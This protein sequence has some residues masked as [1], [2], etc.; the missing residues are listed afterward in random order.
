MWFI[1]CR[2]PL[3][4]YITQFLLVSVKF[5]I[6]WLK[7]SFV[8][9]SCYFFCRPK[10][11]QN[12]FFLSSAELMFSVGKTINLTNLL[13]SK[14]TAF[15]FMPLVLKIRGCIV[16]VLSVAYILSHTFWSFQFKWNK[17]YNRPL[18]LWSESQWRLL[19]TCFQQKNLLKQRNFHQRRFLKI[20]FYG[21]TA[22]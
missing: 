13:I 15:K 4:P 2:L 20:I 17:I 10:K 7:Y 6:A 5:G 19:W 22:L 18:R 12:T 11:L 1:I 9:R 3:F 21:F 8:L 14:A 16:F